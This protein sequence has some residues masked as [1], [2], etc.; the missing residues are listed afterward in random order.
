[1]NRNG[2]D[3]DDQPFRFSQLRWKPSD[4][5]PLVKGLE[6]PLVLV[7]HPSVDARNI[8]EL[9]AWVRAQGGKVRMPPSV[10]VHRHTS[11]A[12]NLQKS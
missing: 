9:A 12:I 3:A 1:V 7:A 10:Q 6:A 4:F 8:D 11:S 2:F 5:Q